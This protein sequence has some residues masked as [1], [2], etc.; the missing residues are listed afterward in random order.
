MRVLT[1]NVVRNSELLNAPDV[2]GTLTYGNV[3]STGLYVERSS[4]HAGASVP[5]GSARK[6]DQRHVVVASHSTCVAYGHAVGATTAPRT[7]AATERRRRRRRII[8]CL[9][10]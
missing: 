9:K 1:V 8:A 6:V 5:P 3:A 4:R 7:H 2:V 10:E